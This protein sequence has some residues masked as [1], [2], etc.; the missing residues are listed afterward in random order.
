MRTLSRLVILA[1][2]I[3]GLFFILGTGVVLGAGN[4]LL[5]AIN[6]SS[7]HGVA[8]LYPASNGKSINLQLQFDGLLS[9][10]S[11]EVSLDRKQCGGSLL[12]DVGKITSDA[13]GHVA[14]IF[15]L[16]P[17]GSALQH[18]VWLD[19][20]QGTSTSAASV[21]C[22]QVQVNSALLSNFPQNSIQNRHPLNPEPGLP[23]TGVAPAKNN[24]YDNYTF[25]RKY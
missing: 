18:P 11:Y 14:A 1:V 3:V 12:L 24:S 5:K 15:S 19:I 7:A 10:T 23:G 21:A 4:A 13:N 9:N 2:V 8:E 20:H 25:P 17:L 16:A 22:G 6:G